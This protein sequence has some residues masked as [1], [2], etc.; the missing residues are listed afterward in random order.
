MSVAVARVHLGLTD[1]PDRLTRDGPCRVEDAQLGPAS[2]NGSAP[3]PAAP[4]APAE[5]PAP[6]GGF[7]GGPSADT[8]SSDSFND[9]VRRELGF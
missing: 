5:Q 3:P 1:R 7:G 6:E 8:P 2:L 9:Q 4:A